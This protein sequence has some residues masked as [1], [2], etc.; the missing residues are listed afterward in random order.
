[1]NRNIV[2]VVLLFVGGVMSACS[3]MGSMKGGSSDLISALTNQLGVTNAQAEGGTGSILALAQQKLPAGDFGSIA[4]AIPG[5][6]KYL[7]I[8]KQL[9][10]GASITD[11]AGL[12]SAFSMLG[13]SPDM[14]GKFSPIV[15]DYVGKAGGDR[16]KN[17]L[18]GVLK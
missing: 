13:M 15:T 5:S 3:S 17:L 7:A 4:K 6:D 16:A 18:A 14:L 10:G 9:L 8:A 1:M 12:Q 11:K 2:F